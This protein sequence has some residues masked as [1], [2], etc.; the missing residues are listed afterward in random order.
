M[1]GRVVVVL[2]TALSACSAEASRERAVEPSTAPPPSASATSAAPSPP[3]TRE[4][5]NPWGTVARRTD[6][7]TNLQVPWSIVFL[8]DGTGLVAE[9]P[10]GRVLLLRP[11]RAPRQV[12]RLPSTDLGEGGLLGL[13]VSPTYAADR[14]VYAYYT[15]DVDN[16]VV[17]FRLGSVPKVVLGGIPSGSVHN[18]GRIAFGPDGMLYVGTG[19]TGDGDLAQ[20]RSS[21]GGKILRIRPDGSVPGDNPFR[22]SPVWSYGH[23]NVQGLAWDPRGRLYATEF[24]QNAYDEINRIEP[25]G[26]YGWPLVE[27][28][29]DDRR[30]IDP[31][32]TWSTDEASPS[33]V[34]YA[35]GSMYVAALRGDRLW[36]VR[37][38]GHGGIRGARAL[39]RDELGRIRH[40]A[41]GPD[42]ALWLLTSNRDGRG[43]PRA[44]DDRVVRLPLPM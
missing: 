28:R 11:G 12:A 23:R 3:P 25:G 24:G 27:G 18:G 22:G 26:N 35:H 15:T 29:G 21:L 32:L 41:L 37:L 10:T 40:A 39:L 14:L 4:T 31:L 42:G 2:V 17:R 19:E 34:A 20:N 30:F 7:A 13:A 38:D 1:A 44:G 16:R 6:V 9:R 8:P 36:R 5:R 43:D 33:G